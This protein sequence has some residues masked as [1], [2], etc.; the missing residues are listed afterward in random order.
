MLIMNIYRPQDDEE[1]EKKE[2]EL[3]ERMKLELKEN[4]QVSAPNREGS[5]CPCVTR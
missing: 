3:R 1:R 4:I 5:Q 2:E